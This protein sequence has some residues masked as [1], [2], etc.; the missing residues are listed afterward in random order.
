MALA[1][2]RRIASRAGRLMGRDIRRRR[3]AASPTDRLHHFRDVA[4]TAEDFTETFHDNGR[5]TCPRC[6]GSITKSASRT[7]S[8]RPRASARRRGRFTARLCHLPALRA[9]Y[10]KGIVPRA[11]LHPASFASDHGTTDHKT[12]GPFG[13]MTCSQRVFAFMTL[14]AKERRTHKDGFG[15]LRSL[16]SLAANS[17]WLHKA[18]VRISAPNPIFTP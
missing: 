11:R 9:G 18:A 17:V 10:L 8:G 7:S 4:G 1:T 13:N 3:C 2:R 15:S 12:T 16:R 5:L 6:S 14:V